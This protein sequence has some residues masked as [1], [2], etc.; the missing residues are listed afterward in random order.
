MGQMGSVLAAALVCLNIVAC[1]MCGCKKDLGTCSS[2]SRPGY[3]ITWNDN[4]AKMGDELDLTDASTEKTTLQI[5]KHY[6]YISIRRDTNI[7]HIITANA[8]CRGDGV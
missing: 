7:T 2:F 6:L 8:D 3:A 1:Y 4:S 5:F